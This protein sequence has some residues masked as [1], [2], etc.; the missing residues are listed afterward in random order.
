MVFF[1]VSGGALKPEKCYWYFARFIWINGQWRFSKDTPPPLLITA[2][3]GNR[4]T[5]EYK[6]PA[7][8]TKAVGVWQDLLGNSSQ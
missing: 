6:Q 3:D 1:R 7:D 5:I 4:T 8:A 2:D